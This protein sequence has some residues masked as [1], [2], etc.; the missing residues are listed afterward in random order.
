MAQYF[1]LSSVCLNLSLAYHLSG[2]HLDTYSVLMVSFCVPLFNHSFIC[3]LMLKVL[4][5]IY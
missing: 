4:L 2:E 1:V 5:F 3:S